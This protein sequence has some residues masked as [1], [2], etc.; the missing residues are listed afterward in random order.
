EIE[1]AELPV[2]ETSGKMAYLV[3]RGT[4]APSFPC[5][6]GTVG[7]EQRRHEAAPEPAM[8]NRFQHRRQ[9]G[10]SQKSEYRSGYDGADASANRFPPKVVIV[11][12]HWELVDSCLLG[13]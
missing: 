1:P 8:S 13:D 9:S 10:F 12:P 2:A 7:D 11:A 3:H 4:G 6:K 5:Q